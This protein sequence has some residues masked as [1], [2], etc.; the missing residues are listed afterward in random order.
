MWPKTPYTLILINSLSFEL[1]CVYRF[2]LAKSSKIPSSFASINIVTL[3][4][5]VCHNPYL[6]IEESYVI[7]N[8]W[9]NKMHQMISIWRDRN[10]HK[11]NGILC[12]VLRLF[13]KLYHLLSH[14]IKLSIHYVS[15]PNLQTSKPLLSHKYVSQ[16]ISYSTCSSTFFRKLA[17][18][19]NHIIQKLDTITVI[20]F[21]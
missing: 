7:V 15:Y 16:Y 5:C 3:M 20:L 9:D 2:W 17:R 18:T 19:K 11:I 4:I 1:L 6:N 12:V 8:T 21:D 14:T 13:L 10:M